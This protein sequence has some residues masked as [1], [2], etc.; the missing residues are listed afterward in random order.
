MGAEGAA[1][2][3][4][5]GGE[6]MGAG[7][8]PAVGA[9]ASAL[10]GTA[11]G[12]GSFGGGDFYGTGV[13]ATAG[14]GVYD[15][16]VGRDASSMTGTPYGGG[17]FGTTGFD[18]GKFWSEFGEPT[19]NRLLGSGGRS[20]G[21]GTAMVGSPPE[22]ASFGAGAQATLPAQTQTPRPRPAAVGPSNLTTPR[23][24]QSFA[25]AV[26]AALGGGR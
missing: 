18:W 19:L 5:Y 13:P 15:P 10:S 25:A 8:D 24:R 21:G 3:A 22:A 4:T 20:R 6:G 9:D 26:E 1:A 2:G 7:Y 23:S 11:Q 12:G 16:F 14:G 17:S